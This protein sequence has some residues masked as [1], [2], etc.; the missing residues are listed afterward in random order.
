MIG[1]QIPLNSQAFFGA[2]KIVEHITQVFP[3]LPIKHFSPAVR[4]PHH[5]VLAIPFCVA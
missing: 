3:E 1:L 5:M 4:S 2:G